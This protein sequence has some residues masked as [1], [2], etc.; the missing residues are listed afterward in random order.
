MCRI[1]SLWLNLLDCSAQ[2]N[3]YFLYYYYILLLLKPFFMLMVLSHGI[4]PNF[5]INWPNHLN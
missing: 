4:K 3:C 5:T 2:F 1:F